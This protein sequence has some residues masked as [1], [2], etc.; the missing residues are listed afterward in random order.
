MR[1]LA[2]AVAARAAKATVRLDEWLTPSFGYSLRDVVVLADVQSSFQHVQLIESPTFGVALRLDGAMQCSEKDE[3]FYHEPLVH[4]ALLHA[5]NLDHVLIVGGGDGGAAE[6]ALKWS[7]LGRLD[8]VEIDA[9]V[10]E[11]S[12]RYLAAIHRGVLDGVDRRYRCRVADGRRWVADAP[13]GHYD[14]IVLDLTDAGGPSTALYGREF[15]A[16]CSRALCPGG[17][18]ALHLAAP[19]AQRLTCEQML[20]RLRQEF[21]AVKPYIVSVPMSGGQW[22]MALC[23]SQP[24]PDLRDDA[25][26]DQRLG[27]LR[28]RRLRIM[29]AEVMKGMFALPP[30]LSDATV[31]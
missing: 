15:F 4:V 17:V 27:D 6:E 29:T 2:P 5:A 22:M 11:L 12:R 7:G 21:G 26:I 10:L 24:L 23:G 19:W 8:H 20:R 1:E 14:V 28:G 16:A 9:T 25:S 31:E 3:F 18:L 30:Y 13:A